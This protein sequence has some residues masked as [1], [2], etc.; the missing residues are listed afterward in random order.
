MGLSIADRDSILNER[1]RGGAS[2]APA[3]YYVFLL[4]TN[5]TDDT[6]AGAVEVSTANW[7]NYA[8]QSIPNAAGSWGAPAGGTTTPQQVS[9]TSVIDFG[10]AATTGN[11]TI[12]GW[13]IRDALTGGAWR[14]WAA[15]AT[16]P[17]VQNAQPCSF[18]P[19]ALIM[20]L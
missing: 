13:G 6:G 17:I 15:F 19:G 9:N 20:T 18:A 3:T 8:R 4:T 10:T 1:F 14:G 2:N 16:P 11:Q 7:T 5:P 12:T